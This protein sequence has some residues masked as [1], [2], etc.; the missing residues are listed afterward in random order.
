MPK[1]IVQSL[2]AATISASTCLYGCGPHK[3]LESATAEVT[4]FH[5]QYDRERYEDIYAQADPGMR[6]R[7]TSSE[8]V[9][10]LG[11]NREKL[12]PVKASEM[13][14]WHHSTLGS[15]TLLVTTYRTS[16]AKGAGTEIFT[17]RTV[18][19]RAAL[20]AYSIDSPLIQAK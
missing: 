15:D 3:A 1:S 13:T 19:A 20:L 16:F 10:R 18:S 7:I 5:V 8:W 2:V 9:S 11:A 12:G 14:E 6:S 17:F 4:H